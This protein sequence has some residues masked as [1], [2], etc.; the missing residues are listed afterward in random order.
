MK[1][2]RYRVVGKSLCPE[3]Q[4]RKENRKLIDT[5][6]SSCTWFRYNNVNNLLKF[7]A[8]L[9]VNFPTWVFFNVYEYIKG[10]NGKKLASFVK[11]KEEPTTKLL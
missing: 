10:E 7:K 2:K 9:D 6:C 8:F 1:A 3:C 11:G 5:N 4:W